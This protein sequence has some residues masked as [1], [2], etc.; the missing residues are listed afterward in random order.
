[1]IAG[2]LTP[3]DGAITRTRGIKIGYLAQIPEFAQ[4]VTVR[5]AVIGDLANALDDGAGWEAIGAAE[6]YLSRLGLSSRENSLEDAKVSSLSGGLKKKVALARELAKRPDLL[7]LDEPTNHLDLESILW[8]EEFVRSAPMAVMTIS[9]DRAFLSNIAKRVIEVD[10]RN[11]DG[12]LSVD[13]NYDD[14]LSTK[15]T[16]LANLASM[17]DSMENTLRREIEWLRR[18]AKARTTKQ[19]ARIDRA[20]SLESETQNLRDKTRESKLKLEFQAT[21]GAPKRLIKA[22]GISKSYG[23]KTLF[24]GLDLLLTHRTR[25]GLIGRNGIGKSTL[26]RI[27]TGEEEPDTGSVER[28]QR[29]EVAYFEQNRSTLDPSLSVLRSICPYG[30]TV[31]F[32]GRKIHVRSYLERFLFDARMA[33][34]EVSKL[35]GGEQSRLLLAKLMLEP[36]NLLVLDEPTN[37]LDIA[38]LGILEECLEEFPGAVILVSHD[39]SFMDSVC[40]QLLGFPEMIVYADMSQWQTAWK[41]RQKRENQKSASPTA[42]TP[43]STT[44]TPASSAHSSA[45]SAKKRKLSFKEQREFDSMESVILEK[46]ERLAKLQ[47]DSSLSENVAN[48]VRLTEMMKE[49]ADLQSEIDRLYA[50]WSE[51]ETLVN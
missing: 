45:G 28:S 17:R 10:R 32:Q 46:E 42:S 2:E 35:S 15:E 9:H 31:E 14:F 30:E 3:D 5:E 7:L 21:D 24:T 20:Y 26:I 8:L 12:I 19:K 18:G 22:E 34:L 50:R 39:R 1:M 37:D 25:L 40:D 4:D 36:A 29:L 51:L 47:A 11:P 48:A 44:S 49:M 27:L 33:D 16:Y 23:E 13:G 6:E 41:E 43:A 38:T